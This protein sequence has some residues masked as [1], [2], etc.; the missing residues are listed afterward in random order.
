M[1]GLTDPIDD[2]GVATSRYLDSF[3][4]GTR[5]EVTDKLKAY[6]DLGVTE[7]VCWFM[8]FP[9]DRSMRT[10]ATEIRPLL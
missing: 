7:V 3:I 1:V 9:S 10:L 5:Q 4:I 8:D 2:R 6:K